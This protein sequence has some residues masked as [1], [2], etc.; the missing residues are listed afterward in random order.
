MNT[1][2]RQ[3]RAASFEGLIM[4]AEAAGDAAAQACRPRPII[5]GSP[6]DGIFG[7]EIDYSKTT[8]YESD[9]LCGFAWI[10][11]KP[12]TSA[13]ARHLRAS[14]RARADYYYGGVTVWVSGYN[15]SVERKEAYARAYAK[16]LS[17]AGITATSDSRLD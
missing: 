2:Q 6:K 15:Q 4:A 7:N 5:I 8:Y 11:I 16:V 3:S 1:K 17:D 12:G 10:N 9:G 14:G 13:F